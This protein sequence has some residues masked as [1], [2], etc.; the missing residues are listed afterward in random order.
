MQRSYG[1]A[2]SLR[3]PPQ[4]RAPHFKAI[5]GHLWPAAPLPPGISPLRLIIG[6]CSWGHQHAWH[7]VIPIVYHVLKLLQLLLLKK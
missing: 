5:S 7:P 3:S 1:I 6:L 4:R 2:R